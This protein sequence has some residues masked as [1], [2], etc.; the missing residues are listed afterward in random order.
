MPYETFLEPNPQC[1]ASMTCPSMASSPDGIRLYED[2]QGGLFAT[3]VIAND[4]ANLYRYIVDCGPP[5][6]SEHAEC[7]YD[8]FFMAIVNGC[9]DTLRVLAE[10]YQSD[11]CEKKPLR[12]RLERQ[13]I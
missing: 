11:H 7:D 2:D 8:Y 3:I 5:L 13:N 4:V 10:I 12:S 9:T 1:G 6:F